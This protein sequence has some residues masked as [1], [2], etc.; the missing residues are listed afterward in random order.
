VTRR[1]KSIPA[2]LALGSL[3]LAV[4]QR[5]GT[6]VTETKVNL[7]TDPGAFLAA[8]TSNWSSTADLG[9]VWA[10]QYGG[11][12]W[13]MAPWFAFGHALGLPMWLVDR[14]WLGVLLALAAWGVV[15]ML[16]ALADR[17]RG[18]LHLVAGALYV[19]N[20]YVTV[21]ANRISIALLAYAA[22]PWMLLCVHRGL[23]D[24]RSWAWPA[25]FALV[26][27]CTGG[28]VNVAVT[29]WVLVGPLLFL[30]YERLFAGVGPGALRPFL[31]RMV[32][33]NLLASA[34]WIVPVLVAAKYGTNFL[35]YTEQPGTIWSTSSLPESLRLMGFWTSYV[36]VG[37]GGTLYPYASFGHAFLFHPPIE[38]ASLLVPALAL[39]G[40]AWTRRWRYGPW[41]LLLTLVGVLIMSAGFPDGT[42]LRQ[43]L[44]FAYNHFSA[45]Q[46]LRT[47]YKAGPL[48]ALG[49]ACLAGAGFAMLWAWLQRPLWRLGAAGVAVAIAALAAWPLVSGKAPERQLAL[50]HGVPLAWQD[51]ARA[52]D[53]RD[54]STRALSLP[55]QPFSYYKWGG[56]VDHVITGLTDHPVLTRYIVPFEDLRAADLQWST[57]ALVSQ[58]RAVPGQLAP[59]LDLLGVGD[60]LLASDG[61]RARSG[62][63]SAAAAADLLSDQGLVDQ[64]DPGAPACADLAGEL[65]AWLPGGHLARGPAALGMSTFGPLETVDRPAGRI[66][67]AAHLPEVT[68]VRTRTAGI[69]RLLPQGPMTI[70]DGS[71]QGLVDLAAFGA[72]P[73]RTPIAYAAD[74][75]AKKL[76]ALAAGGANLVV[77]DSN[78]RSGFIS[79]RLR[80]NVGHVMQATENVDSNGIVLDP[81]GTTG[82]T[83]AQTIA[84][85]HGVRSITSPFSPEVT[86]FAEHRPFAAL[87]G[88]VHTAWLA[89]RWLAPERHHLDIAFDAPRDVPSID[90]NP[91]S[92]ARGVVRHVLVD[93]RLRFAVHPG[94]NHLR[95]GLRHVS[96]LTI[97]MVDVKKPKHGSAGG[98]GI[99][100][101]RISGVRVT[102]R[103][104]SPVLLANA[105]R[106]VSLDGD[107]LTYLFGRVTADAPSWR[108]P[109]GG[110]YQ[111]GLMRDQQDPEP[112][113]ARTFALP[114]ARTFDARAWVRPRLHAPDDAFD[115]LAGAHGDV[116]ATGS[117]RFGGAPLYRA[118]SA[119]DGDPQTAWVASW[120]PGRRAW[121]RWRTG[122]PRT[123]AALRLVAPSFVVR[124]PTLVQLTVDGHS[125]GPLPVRT[126]GIVSLPAPLRGR[127]VRLDVLRARFPLGA[128]GQARQRRAVGIADIVGAPRLSVPRSGNISDACLTLGAV[129][130]RPLRLRVHGDIATMDGDG[131]LSGRRCGPALTLAAGD[132]DLLGHSADF[133]IDQLALRSAAPQARIAPP[134][135]R[136]VAQGT[137]GHG[138]R[139]GVRLDVRSPGWLVLGEG[140]NNGWTATCDGH[141]LG[142]PTPLEGFANAWPVKPGCRSVAFR[143]GPDRLLLPFYLLSLLAALA[144]AALVFRRR[145]AMGAPAADAPVP[146]PDE[147]PVRYWPLEGALAAGVVAFLVV[148]FVFAL[149]AGLVA[150]PVVA[151]LLYKGVS[152][153]RLVLAALAALAIVVP[154]LYLIFPGKDPGGYSTYYATAHFGAHWV[155]V[156]AIVLIGIA[157]L[158]ALRDARA[159]V[160]R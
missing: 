50:P 3:V 12:V 158:R 152:A 80:G 2:L 60:V 138:G 98:G 141:S 68:D 97:R 99:R 90:L 123:F 18:A 159:S 128:S 96:S 76:R 54:D 73:T 4:C 132:H 51:V 6:L 144:F 67:P 160:T 145:R 83:G 49:L 78:R 42:P 142:A 71:A 151:F 116:V 69:V 7:H 32:V 94:W 150:A 16:D 45:L 35:P 155:A 120:M 33:T 112:Q 95:L 47:T 57:D 79:S 41:F 77:S 146:V 10:G 30:A 89:D 44:T 58:E 102:E 53:H 13:P 135:G 156:G 130:G 124:R 64:P 126:G 157:L 133:V 29:A 59:L 34:W 113:L 24:P 108:N 118:S 48:A 122:L 87:D 104:R 20:P 127:D 23:R 61:D 15:R 131:P 114:A 65:C 72:L 115:R 93:E 92:D 1:E 148:G 91:Y 31:G 139:H 28:G 14:L 110:L 147:G 19:V 119:L 125:S 81:F 154:A 101:L 66:A 11:Y 106:G 43:G 5:P 8:V 121:L 105:L 63:T 36:G 74:L 107:G 75:D 136:V 56:T 55:G 22:L 85:L 129:D 109:T 140:Y 39:G 70:V 117:E 40:F 88:N 26:L 17:R 38:V 103:L 46:F 111:A 100:E 153:R 84:V 134:V 86:Q 62:E 37:Y 82:G 27:T 143:F 149:R 9:H 137:L 21:Y 52:L 25:A